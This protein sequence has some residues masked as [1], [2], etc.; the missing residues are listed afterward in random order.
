MQVIVAVCEKPD[1]KRLKQVLDPLGAHKHG[2]DNDE[3]PR[4][5][6]DTFGKVHF[7]EGLRDYE[8]C[9]KPVHHCNS[10]LACTQR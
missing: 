10:K 2:R 4:F 9:R 6:R 8:H 3:C 5:G 7:R 1:L